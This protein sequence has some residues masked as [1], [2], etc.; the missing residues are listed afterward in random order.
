MAISVGAPRRVGDI[1]LPSFIAYIN[2][3]GELV[4]TIISKTKIADTNDLSEAVKSWRVACGVASLPD[5]PKRQK[6]WDLPI[7][8]KNWDNMLRE[9]DQLSRA[10]L[11]ATAQKETGAWLNALPV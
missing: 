11:L 10:T 3:V 5:D 4:E 7:V 8:E 1:A 2:S 6:A 9:A